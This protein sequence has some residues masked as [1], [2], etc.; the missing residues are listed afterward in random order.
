M[1]KNMDEISKQ[2]IDRIAHLCTKAIIERLL[3]LGILAQEHRQELL[4]R[5]DNF[6]AM[7]RS[8][9]LKG[10]LNGKYSAFNDPSTAY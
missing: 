3:E 8:E 5:V 6:F 2:A 4:R 10:H 1:R 7:R 9:A